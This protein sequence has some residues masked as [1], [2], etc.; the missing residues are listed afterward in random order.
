MSEDLANFDHY[1]KRRFSQSSTPIH[2][3]SDLRIFFHS[4]GNKTTEAVTATDIDDFVDHQIAVGR[5]PTTINR[6]LSTIHT[7]FEFLA[8]ERPGRSWPNPVINRRHRLKTGS[9]L[10]RDV[11]DNDVARIF[12]VISDERDRA[13]FGLMVGA[14]L[15]V[16]EVATLQLGDVEEP[17]SPDKLAKLRVLGKG[18]KERV[19][20]LT[21][22]LL[23]TLQA[24]LRVRPNADN[25]R[26]FLNWRGHPITVNGIQWCLTQYAK[27]AD[28]T[29]SCHRL[30]HTFGRRMAENGLPIDSLARLLGHSHLQTTQCYIDGAD[31]TVRADFTEAMKHLE[32][33]LIRDKKVSSPHQRPSTTPQPR[34]APEAGLRKLRQRLNVLPPWLANAVDANLSWRWPTWRGQ[35]AYRLGGNFISLVIRISSWLE[36]HRQIE[37]W[38]SFRRVDLQAW[39]ES[40]YQDDVSDVTIRNELAR[41]RGLLKFLETRD[42]PIDPGLFRVQPPQQNAKPLPRYLPEADYRWLETN[43]L[44]ATRED[45]YDACFDRAW[46]LTLAHTGV[47]LSEMLDLRLSDLDLDKGLATVRGG[48]PDRD[49]VVFLTPQLVNALGRYLDRRPDLSDDDH[50]FIL[51][52]RSPTARTIQRRLTGFGERSGLHVSPHRLRHTIATRLINQGMPIHSLKKLLGHQRLDTTQLYA[53]IYDETLYQ[54]FK[55]AM[56]RLEGIPAYSWSSPETR[57]QTLVSVTLERV[58]SV[59]RNPDGYRTLG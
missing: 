2:Y 25:N 55:E 41:F 42:Y 29:L 20:W 49:R 26:L 43:V 21:E 44:Q 23:N 34:S 51:H 53:R 16:G 9:H 5:K 58:P 40:R 39:L 8:G 30:R 46:F 6:R 19:V 52:S 50:V 4:N 14:G 54:Q 12:A 1:L 57:K 33:N 11:L 45:T 24:W 38:E 17:T 15:R 18:N 13:M 36:I 27:A 10:P 3:L 47:R 37:G 28:V 7:F 59:A 56:S 31:P 32:T 48:K 35:T 22:S